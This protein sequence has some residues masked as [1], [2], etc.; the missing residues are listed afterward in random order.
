MRIGN[1]ALD[2]ELM[3]AWG[4]K[5]GLALVILI[6]TWL[7]A[8]AAK[9][10]FAKLVDNVKF[11]QRDTSS[12][13]SV[14]E[15]L[16]KIVSLLIWLFGLLIIL[17][18]LGLGGVDAPIQTLLNSI[19]GFVPNLLGAAI[20]FFI[21]IVVARIVRDLVVTFLQTV[22]FD[23][24]ANRGGI[25]AVTGNST[26][27]KTIGTIIYVLIIIPVAILALEALN[28]ESV[29]GP[30]SNMLRMILEAIPNIIGAAIILGI[31]YLISKFVVQII[32]EIL[33][34]LGVDQSMAALD[35]LPA[36]TTLTSVVARIAQVAI[37]LFFAIAAM[38]LLGFAELTSILDQVLELGGRVIFGAIVIAVG[39]LIANL[40][41]KIIGGAA[42][43][44]MAA[45]IVR[46]ATI[47]LF[48]FMGLQFMGVGEEIV[49]TAFTALVIGGAAAAALAFG[50]GGRHVAGKVLEELHANPPKP[51]APA[52][53][54]PAAAKP[55][56]RKPA[57]KK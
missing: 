17:R 30:A 16:G 54:K 9:W 2:T 39:F 46:Y 45:T 32:T 44:S 7:V 57:A 42:E 41:S 40:L 26:I 10:T 5:L 34:G 29:S 28:L 48:T 37:M 14:G 11:L 38:R 18:V 13:A 36:R 33:P 22:D 31:G 4:E 50:W 27:S 52:A 15:S 25:D 1:Y 24:W 3:M 8:R 20:I 47:I 23:K 19:M 35:I 56:A 51:K 49:Q 53:R 43:G 55:A 12:G 21:G 6:G